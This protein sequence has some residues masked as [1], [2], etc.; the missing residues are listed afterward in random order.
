MRRAAEGVPG[1]DSG[2]KAL[3]FLFQNLVSHSGGEFFTSELGVWALA[4]VVAAVDGLPCPR[5]TAID[6]GPGWLGNGIFQMGTLWFGHTEL[7]LHKYS[8]GLK[9][10]PTGWGLRAKWCFSAAALPSPFSAAWPVPWPRTP[11]REGAA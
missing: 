4:L 11:P 5:D 6:V 1:E 9:Q 8:W 2:L 7:S 10:L 3:C